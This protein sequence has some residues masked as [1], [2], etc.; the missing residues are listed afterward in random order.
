MAMDPNQ[1]E[2][3]AKMNAAISGLQAAIAA[4]HALAPE[5]ASLP[6]PKAQALCAQIQSQCQPQL[7]A[8]ND[9]M[10]TANEF[11]SV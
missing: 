4:M 9:Y 7:D 8:L 10:S 6:V 11:S 2:I 3:S 5:I 1:A